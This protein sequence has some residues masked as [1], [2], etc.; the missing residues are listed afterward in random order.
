MTNRLIGIY[1]TN[2][3]LNKH[4]H[5]QHIY[6]IVLFLMVSLCCVCIYVYPKV[7]HAGQKF[8]YKNNNYCSENKIKFNKVMDYSA[9]N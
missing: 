7:V 5:T 9:M 1:F 6:A 8:N 3:L 4:T 2:M